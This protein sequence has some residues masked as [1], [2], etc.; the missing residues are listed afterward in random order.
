MS[1]VRLDSPCRPPVGAG[2]LV[3]LALLL[4][5]SLAGCARRW[6]NDLNDYSTLHTDQ[7][8]CRQKGGFI[9]EVV[10]VRFNVCM[11]SLGWRQC[12]DGEK[13]R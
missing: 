12:Q 8:Y 1:L 5:L 2:R 6:C 4:L 10:P 3:L 9:S 7:D 11:E 13:G